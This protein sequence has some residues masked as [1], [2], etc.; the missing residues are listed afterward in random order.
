MLGA[1]GIDDVLEE[2][3][4]RWQ[5]LMP[6]TTSLSS[7]VSSR[8]DADVLR[9]AST[10]RWQKRS[11]PR[12][13]WSARSASTTV[14][15]SVADELDHLAD[16]LAITRVDVRAGERPRVVGCIVTGFP[17]TRRR[18]LDW[19]RPLSGPRL[20]AD[21]R[22]ARSTSTLT[23][24]RV[25]DLVR[26]AAAASPCR[27]RHVAP[28]QGRRRSWRRQCPGGL[29][30]LTEGRLI[31]VPGDRHEV[32]MAACLAALNGTPARGAAAHGRHRA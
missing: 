25:K 27:G 29:R 14:M 10:R 3:V 20:A 11:T 19:L 6:S 23:Q 4:Q 1:G 18:P 9:R 8:P 17:T 5:P 15:P 30:V 13:S 7:R 31:V 22:G 12:S 16:T 26:R 21:R 2:V 24:P 28:D 32:I